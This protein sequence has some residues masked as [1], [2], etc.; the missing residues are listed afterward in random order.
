VERVVAGLDQVISHAEM[1]AGVGRVDATFG[2]AVSPDEALDSNEL[3]RLA[4]ARLMERKRGGRKPRGPVRLL[5]PEPA[6]V[7]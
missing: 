7:S 3:F 5:H 6:A 2:W 1:P 4:D